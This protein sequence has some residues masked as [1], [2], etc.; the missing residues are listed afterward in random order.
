M[1]FM[2]CGLSMFWDEICT[3]LFPIYT[4][5]IHIDGTDWDKM[6]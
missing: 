1:I 5:T 6:V 3:L 2:Y 4:L